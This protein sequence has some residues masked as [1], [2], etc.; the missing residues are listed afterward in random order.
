MSKKH[1]T[2]VSEL[3]SEASY[4]ILYPESITIPGDERSRTNPGHGYPEHSVDYWRIE[5][6]ASKEEWEAEISRLSKRKSHSHEEFKA[7][8]MIPAKVSTIVN[9]SVEE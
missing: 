6:F 3:P 1:P 2:T 7:V 8:R 4:A 9:V 5:M